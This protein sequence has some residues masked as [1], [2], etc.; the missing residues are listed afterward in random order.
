MIATDRRDV[1]ERPPEA[2]DESRRMRP[3][4]LGVDRPAGSWGGRG[5]FGVIVAVGADHAGYRMKAT[6][7]ETVRSAGHEPLDLGTDSEAAVDYPDIAVAVG[8]AVLEGRAARGILICGSGV[9]AAVA[10]NKLKGIRAGVCHDTYSAAQSVEHD[11]ANVLSI[12]ARVVGEALAAELVR[13]FLRASFSG[14]E[15]HVRRLR[16][17][18]AIERGE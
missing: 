5:G 2:R 4:G 1:G 17:I 9:G 6:V 8:R 14:E 16:K 3:P 10:A 11:D 15:R 18:E 13:A 12:G 7:L